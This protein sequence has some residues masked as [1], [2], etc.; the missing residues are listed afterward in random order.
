MNSEKLQITTPTD[1]EI[2][3]TRVFNAPRRLVF[4]AL[5][6]PELVKRWLLGPPGWSMPVCEIDLRVGGKYR[7]VWR[8][9]S[10]GTDMGMGGVYREIVAPERIVATEKFDQ[11]WYSGEAVGTARLAE[12]SGKTTLTQTVLYESKETRDAVLRSPMESGVAASY[13]RLSDVLAS[14]PAAGTK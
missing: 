4:D 7:Y 5:T 11:A 10:D 2:A 6:K 1:R 8:R 13:D 3:M 12:Q 14:M 9:D